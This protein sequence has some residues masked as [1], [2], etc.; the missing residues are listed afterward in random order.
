M[1]H[2]FKAFQGNVVVEGNF[3]QGDSQQAILVQAGQDV[4]CQRAVVGLQ[5]GSD[6]PQHILSQAFAGRGQIFI[7]E[8]R[9]GRVGSKGADRTEIIEIL[10]WGKK[11][12][13][14]VGRAAARVGASRAGRAAR[15]QAM[16]GGA[17]LFF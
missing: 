6:L 3:V 4:G 2:L 13:W 17:A 15:Q 1:Q 10:G 12:D 16:A 9:G 5:L 14:P 7:W 11:N 8:A